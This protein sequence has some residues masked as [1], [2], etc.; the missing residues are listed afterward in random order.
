MG[1]DV[2]TT[3]P[4]NSFVKPTPKKMMATEKTYREE[5]SYYLGTWRNSYEKARLI[6]EFTFFEKEGG[7]RMSLKNSTESFYQ[8]PWPEGVVTAHSYTPESNDI[9]A[10]KAHFEL[11]DLE[12]FLAINEN[13]G[14]LIIAGYISF[15]GDDSRGDC[16][17]RE[18]F[19]K[20]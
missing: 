20:V 19:Y 3:S 18:F 16:F 5:L 4:V 11:E 13:K 10:F 6:G 9:V 17:V 15:K 8:K 12:A 14:L 7:L 1:A 2:K